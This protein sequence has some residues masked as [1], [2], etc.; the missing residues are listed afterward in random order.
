MDKPWLKEFEEDVAKWRPRW[1]NLY[2][3]D[4]PKVYEYPDYPLKYW[5]NK[6]ADTH[7]E[8][9][10]IL[11]GDF[12]M[13]YGDANRIARRLAN[14]LLQLGVK[15]GDRVAIMAPNVPQYVISLQALF[16]IGAI[17]V[18]TNPLYT[19]PELDLQ[20]KDSGTETVIVIAAYADKA[21]QIMKDPASPVKQV[22]TFQLPGLPAEIEKGE[23]I[24]DFDQIVHTASESEPDITVLGDDIAR[25]Q[26]TG[27]TTGIPKAAMATH[28]NLV[29]D[30]LQ[31][32][33][34]LGITDETAPRF[35]AAIPF[36][37]VYGMVA[38]MNIA[39]ATGSTLYLHP[40]FDV[41]DVLK[42]IQDEKID[43]F[44]GVPTMYVAVNNS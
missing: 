42:T 5:F 21:I 36:F 9:P 27:G 8:K 14:R 6:W 40:K 16:K 32:K 26:Y 24:Y 23:N 25:L 20:F 18:P 1:E 7:P 38:C 28:F 30:T 34:W 3:E 4:V 15:K 12:Q 13:S 22:I 44:P 17:E 31:L 41:K 2:D 37:H 35:L 33:A 11:M 43:Y 29:A 19:V 39:L 10:Y